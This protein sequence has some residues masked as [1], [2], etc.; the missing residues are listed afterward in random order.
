MAPEAKPANDKPWGPDEWERTLRR[1]ANELGYALDIVLA[2][3][4][5]A[6]IAKHNE[7]RRAKQKADEEK[8]T[9]AQLEAK[10]KKDGDKKPFAEQNGQQWLQKLAD[11]SRMR[12]NQSAD[13]S[14]VP[15]MINRDRVG[16][17]GYGN[18]FSWTALKSIK[19]H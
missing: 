7:E 8:L 19:H 4:S 11:R 16:F 10:R 3:P 17:I 6:E 15:K 12:L 14:E 2:L 1:S 13:D 18:K 5:S 9:K